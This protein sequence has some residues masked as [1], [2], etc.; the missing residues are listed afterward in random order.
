MPDNQHT[1]NSLS[2]AA[3]FPFP[4]QVSKGVS[5]FGNIG[6]PHDVFA[7][8][9]DTNAMVV[10]RQGRQYIPSLPEMP[11]SRCHDLSEPLPQNTCL[12]QQLSMK[13]PDNS[14]TPFSLN[15]GQAEPLLQPNLPNSLSDAA[16]F[17][18]LP[19][20]S[21]AMPSDVNTG[22]HHDVFALLRGSDVMLSPSLA[23]GLQQ[24]QQ[25]Q[26]HH[27]PPLI[28][29]LHVM[30]PHQHDLVEPLPQSNLLGQQ[31]STKEPAKSAKDKLVCPE[32]NKSFSYPSEFKRHISVH[33]G[34]RPYPCRECGKTFKM[35]YYL[36]IHRRTHTGYKPYM[37]TIPGCEQAFSQ[38]GHRNRHVRTH[39]ANI[40]KQAKRAIGC[41]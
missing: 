16:I 6:F 20:V 33:T 35:K 29:R 17:P 10:S 2:D 22:S 12:G 19:K 21:T 34:E 18:Y 38:S 9:G 37:C 24:Q 11:P 39:K 25:R 1:S 28:P 15:L 3:L 30:P 8:T 23:R 4:P 26:Q 41:N 5:S 14:A 40:E 36:N 13:E 31:P 27:K 32:C 7:P